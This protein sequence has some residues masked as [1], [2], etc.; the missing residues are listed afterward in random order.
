M[1]STQNAAAKRSDKLVAETQTITIEGATI[2]VKPRTN[3]TV[4]VSIIAD[5]GRHLNVMGEAVPAVTANVIPGR[6]PRKGE[7]VMVGTKLHKVAD[8]GYDDAGILWCTDADG[9]EP[10]RWSDVSHA[11]PVD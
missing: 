3:G 6:L 10:F 7:R 8:F 5:P 9:G 4:V 1:Q 2:T 11:K